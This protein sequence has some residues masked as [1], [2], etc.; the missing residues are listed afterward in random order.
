MQQHKY[1]H[2]YTSTAQQYIFLG[3]YSAR[4][5]RYI[6]ESNM[7]SSEKRTLKIQLE[8][9]TTHQRICGTKGNIYCIKR[10]LPHQI[11]TTPV[12]DATAESWHW[13]TSGGLVSLTAILAIG[14]LW[15]APTGGC[16]ELPPFPLSD[17]SAPGP[18]IME[19]VS[20]TPESSLILTMLSEPETDASRMRLAWLALPPELLCC[21]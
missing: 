14:L 5:Y 1:V 2:T 8:S 15:A 11:I 9:K 13:A 4:E 17:S 12:A 7:L 6:I 10:V 16:T 3:R 19:S 18:S 21:L 20:I